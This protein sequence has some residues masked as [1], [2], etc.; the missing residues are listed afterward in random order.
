[1]YIP[2]WYVRVDDESLRNYEVAWNLIKGIVPLKDKE[3]I[4]NI[5]SILDREEEVMMFMGQ[6]AKEV[7]VLFG[8]T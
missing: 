8:V 3:T 1:M 2:D 4:E 6:L 7:A 5:W